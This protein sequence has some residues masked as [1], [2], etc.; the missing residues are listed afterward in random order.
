MPNCA[1]VICLALVCLGSKVFGQATRV[2]YDVADVRMQTGAPRQQA[3]RSQLTIINGHRLTTVRSTDIEVNPRLNEQFQVPSLT[4]YG[5]FFE[6]VATRGSGGQIDRFT[7]FPSANEPM[8]HRRVATPNFLDHELIF[9]ALGLCDFQ[10][11]YSFRVDFFN[12]HRYQLTN[13][14]PNSL[15]PSRG[16]LK[17][18]C[19]IDVELDQF[20][21]GIRLIRMTE[22]QA[23]TME[24]V[25]KGFRKVDEQYFPEHLTVTTFPRE[26]NSRKYP[27]RKAVL[28]LKSIEDIQ[29]PAWPVPAG[30]TTYDYRMGG[31]N[32]TYRELPRDFQPRVYF[33]PDRLISL[34]ELHNMP[35]YRKEEANEDFFP[36]ESLWFGASGLAILSGFGFAS[37][38]RRRRDLDKLDFLLAS[39]CKFLDD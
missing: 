18:P 35:E 16:E 32:K 33:W 19:T 29:D 25:V 30:V 11:L 4:V 6:G 9:T 38:F 26:R 8:A 17:Y 36:I 3:W 27:L 34:A 14:E 13:S 10:T 20:D 12:A 28:T 37:I 15:K 7:I 5:P 2:V 23:V 24:I 21:R 1:R 22:G 39:G 31:A